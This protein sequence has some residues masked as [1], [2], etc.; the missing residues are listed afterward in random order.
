MCDVSLYCTGGAKLKGTLHFTVA[1]CRSLLYHS[2]GRI[3][4]APYLQIDR[5]IRGI[6]HK[7][8]GEPFEL[9]KPQDLRGLVGASRA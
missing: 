1:G 6:S 2:T 9:R 4:C 5:K 8:P 7:L 3:P